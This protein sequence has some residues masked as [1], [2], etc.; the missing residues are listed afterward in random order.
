M[1][2]GGLKLK[3]TRLGFVDECPGSRIRKDPGHSGGSGRPTDLVIPHTLSRPET[4][5]TSRHTGIGG[6]WSQRSG[7]YLYPWCRQTTFLISH[8]NP[9]FPSSSNPRPL[10][11]RFWLKVKEG[12]VRDRE[13]KDHG[14]DEV[15]ILPHCYPYEISQHS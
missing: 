5:V 1:A 15:D 7:H 6:T 9:Y 4:S 8:W 10:P 3:N 2:P 13:S 12:C 11:D 14:G